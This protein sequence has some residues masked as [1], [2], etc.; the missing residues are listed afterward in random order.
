MGWGHCRL[1]YPE[2]FS[3]FYHPGDPVRAVVG[4]HA[5]AGEVTKSWTTNEDYYDNSDHFVEVRLTSGTLVTYRPGQLWKIS[6]LELLA[7]AA[8]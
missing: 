7:I 2:T 6:L 5:V 3:D 1:N 8:R 4:A